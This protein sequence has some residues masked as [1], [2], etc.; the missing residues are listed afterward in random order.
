MRTDIRI[1]LAVTVAVALLCLY[2]CRLRRTQPAET[3]FFPTAELYY[4]TNDENSDVDWSEEIPVFHYWEEIDQ[5]HYLFDAPSPEQVARWKAL[6]E[7][8][9]PADSVWR[10]AVQ[11]PYLNM[12][13]Y[14]TV[15]DFIELWYHEDSYLLNDSLTLWRLAQYDNRNT[16][17][18]YSNDSE[19]D[20]FQQL[21]NTISGLCLFEGDSQWALN[22]QAGLEE[23]FQM[24]YD[25]LLVR[26]A[27]RHSEDALA[28]ALLH[29]Q[30]AWLGYHAALDSAFRAIDGGA[31]GMVGSAWP[32]AIS[33]I[34]E[35]D[36]LMRARSLEDFYF[37]LTDSLDYEN[38]HR[39]SMIGQY[40]IER[41]APVG[42]GKVLAEYR[43]FMEFFNDKDFFEPEFNY[44]VP[45]LRR[46]LSEEMEAWKG[47]MASRRAVSTL[48]TGLCKDVY[49]NSTNNVRRDKLIMLK[50]RYQEFG[51]TSESINE[52]LLSYGCDDSEIDGFSFEKK[53]NAL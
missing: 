42:E 38:V 20:R 33:G 4:E 48:L 15:H 2:G 43:R 45:V 11:G 25:R 32:M 12:S 29:E 52:C 40:D 5:D 9:N 53:W 44:P 24:F 1:S 10:T 22:F 36:A 50:N 13:Q 3:G 23:D 51:L 46:I 6:C 28:E 17:N 19:F 27:V 47:W 14:M 39:R 34:L 21:K 16:G 7:E 8:R 18:I 49:D 26:E 41:H 30:D 31:V 35:K 37:A